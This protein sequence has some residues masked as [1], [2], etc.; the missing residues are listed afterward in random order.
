MRE[1]IGKALDAWSMRK[2]MGLETQKE[3]ETSSVQKPGV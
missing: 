3:G 1:I 2:K